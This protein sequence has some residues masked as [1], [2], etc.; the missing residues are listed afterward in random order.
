ML[1]GY[2]F[3]CP[4]GFAYWSISK[5]C[6]RINKLD[7]CRG[8]VLPE[9]RWEVPVEMINISYRKRKTMSDAAVSLRTTN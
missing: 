7:Q 9:S 8:A 2:M 4:E 6:E 5:R 3:Q 1:E